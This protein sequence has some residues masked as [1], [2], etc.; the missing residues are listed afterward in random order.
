MMAPR[1]MV[2]PSLS[3]WWPTTTESVSDWT[4]G[5]AGLD[6]T[7]EEALQEKAG[8]LAAGAAEGAPSEGKASSEDV[9]MA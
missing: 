8:L 1:A 6:L 2:L 9:L 3:V 4:G 5:P 7:L